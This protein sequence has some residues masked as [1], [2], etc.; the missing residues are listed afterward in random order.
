[1]SISPHVL[2]FISSAT[3]QYFI[4]TFSESIADSA[5]KNEM[6]D[7]LHD[8]VDEL[9]TSERLARY[10]LD[11]NLV[12]FNDGAVRSGRKDTK[13]LDYPTRDAFI[14]QEVQSLKAIFE[15]MRQQSKTP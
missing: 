14:A 5:A 10:H 12:P 15:M 7:I 3:N 13:S 4:L 8:I 1:M 6:A 2:F 9:T 11:I